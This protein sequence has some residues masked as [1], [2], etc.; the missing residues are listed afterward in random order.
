MLYML[1]YPKYMTKMYD[2]DERV[3]KL[4]AQAWAK[5][6]KDVAAAEAAAEATKDPSRAE[7]TLFLMELIKAR[8]RKKLSQ[9]GLATKLGMQQSAISRIE[10]G[11]ANPSLNTLLK[12]AQALGAELVIKYK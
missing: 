5:L 4:Q 6:Q 9:A 11:K 1:Y 7:R 3:K 10:S 2:Y 8:L 12:I